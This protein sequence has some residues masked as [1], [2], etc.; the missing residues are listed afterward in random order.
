[1]RGGTID[2]AGGSTATTV[3][4]GASSMTTDG[5]GTA[6][7]TNFCGMGLSSLATS[8]VVFRPEVIASPTS[9]PTNR[10]ATL[11]TIT[12]GEGSPTLRFGGRAV[13][14]GAAGLTVSATANC[15]V[16]SPS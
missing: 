9:R 14:T 16:A 6:G 8:V 13:G 5:A 7:A 3:S 11:H 10:S 12:N 15:T 4:G 2:G 1:M